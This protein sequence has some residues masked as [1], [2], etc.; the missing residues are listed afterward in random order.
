MSASVV[1]L[2]LTEFIAGI[3]EAQ[4]LKARFMRSE[5]KRGGQRVRKEFIRR[6]LSGSPGIEG[7]PWRKGK[8]VFSFV[9][10]SS[11]DTADQLEAAVGINRAIR[12]HEEG[13]TFH[14][15]KGSWIYIRKNKGGRGTGVIVA[16]VKQVVIPKRTHFVALCKEMAPSVLRKAG[17]A[18]VRGV[19]VA[20]EKHMKRFIAAAA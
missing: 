2:G 9:T 4:V 5:L 10:G 6:D 14:P 7:G 1:I 17:E 16:R 11:N 15:V 12:V 8:H 13:H 3:K 18:G 20:T 19:V